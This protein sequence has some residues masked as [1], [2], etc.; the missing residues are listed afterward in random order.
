MN[1]RSAWHTILLSAI[2]SWSVAG[3]AQDDDG[4]ITIYS[5]SVELKDATGRLSVDAEI[6]LPREIRE[7]LNSGVP[8]EFIVEL[9]LQRPRRWLPAANLA[10]FQ[11][12]Y[13]LIYYE[14]TRHY[15]VRALDTDISRNFRSLLPALEELG[16]L[17]D[18]MLPIA[19]EQAPSLSGATRASLHIKLNSNALPLPLQPVFTSTWRL[20]SKE[21]QWPLN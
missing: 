6:T 17:R 18:I 20:S 7:G 8:L 1:V 2:V 9:Q 10:T 12:R 15:R 19:S 3:I 16:E 21:Y 11:W 5:A 4:R 14:L 13:S